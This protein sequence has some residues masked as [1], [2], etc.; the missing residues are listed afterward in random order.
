MSDV[1]DVSSELMVVSGTFKGKLKYPKEGP[2]TKPCPACGHPATDDFKC[3]KCH[4]PVHP[5]CG[6]WHGGFSLEKFSCTPCD[7]QV[8]VKASFTEQLEMALG[9]SS[10]AHGNSSVWVQKFQNCFLPV[11]VGDIHV[12]SKSSDPRQNTFVVCGAEDFVRCNSLFR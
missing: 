4:L 5:R 8:P 3:D 9:N 6:N 1:S 12:C 11:S 10:V 2:N 7:I